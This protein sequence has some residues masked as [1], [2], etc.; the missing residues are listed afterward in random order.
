MGS[1]ADLANAMREQS[2]WCEQLGSPFYSALLSRIAD[3]VQ[4][5]GV[6]WR[7]IGPCAADP[8]RFK[9]P[10]RFLAAIHRL[11]LEGKLPDLAWHYPSAGARAT[12]RLPAVCVYVVG[13]SPGRVE[14]VVLHMHGGGYVIGSAA[15]SRREIQNLSTALDCVA[16]SVEYR[17]APE[18]TFPGSLEDNHAALRWMYMNAKELGIDV[19]RIAIK[20][21]SAGGGHAAA[22][23]IAARSQG[24]PHLLSGLDLSHARRPNGFD[25]GDAV[26]P[27]SLSMDA[28]IEP[29]RLDQSAW[30]T[31][32][33]CSRCSIDLF[34]PEDIEYAQRLVAAGVAV[35]L[36]CRA[37]STRSTGS[38]RTPVCRDSSPR[39]GVKL[40][41][42]RLRRLHE[43]LILAGSL[44][45]CGPASVSSVSRGSLASADSFL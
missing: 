23:A 25:A 10:L 27:R 8:A 45:G 3:D 44:L 37:H 14:T 17:L 24:V 15:S 11:V 9:L 42:G 12:R 20:G 26:L 34:A 21:E 35:E 22:L 33:L 18:T 39:R 41:A 7:V 29:F 28:A 4:A 31:G 5:S 32:R 30:G 16:L 2:G 43:A 40:Y 1:P 6:C 36:N 13:I 19:K 38:P